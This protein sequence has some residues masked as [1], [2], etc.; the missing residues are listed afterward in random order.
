MTFVLHSCWLSELQAKRDRYDQQRAASQPGGERD[1][2]SRGG[3]QYRA[4]RYCL[5]DHQSL[6]WNRYP[7]PRDVCR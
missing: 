4:C 3:P 7:W 2:E 6:A 1:G 5:A